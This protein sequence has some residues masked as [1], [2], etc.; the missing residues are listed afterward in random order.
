MA[1]LGIGRTFQNLA[2]F[3]TMTVRAEVS[4]ADVGRLRLGQEAYFSTLGDSDRRYTSTLRQVLPT[5]EVVNNV[6]LYSALFDVPNPEG[7]LMPQM[8]AEVFFV[9]ARA[10]DVPT[11]PA[12]AVETA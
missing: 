10:E 11:V 12:S 2:M 1:P 7:R 4:E 6:V 3:S 5:P 9:V 8:T